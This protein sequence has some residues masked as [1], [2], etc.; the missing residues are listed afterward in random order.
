MSKRPTKSPSKE[1]SRSK[2]GSA[3]IKL[4]IKGSAREVTNAI[5]K[6]ADATGKE[7]SDESNKDR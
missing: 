4:K 1:T 3:V 5:Q 2:R 6:L 7:E